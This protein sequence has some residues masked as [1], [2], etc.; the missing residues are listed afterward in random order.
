MRDAIKWLNDAVSSTS[1]VDA[2]SSYQFTTD[3]I[4]A[5]DGRL[6]A[7]YPIAND[8]T[9]RIPGKELERIVKASPGEPKLNLD[10]DFVYVRSGRFN[11]R[12]PAVVADLNGPFEVEPEW[13]EIPDGLLNAMRKVRPFVSADAS[14]MW[15][16]GLIIQNGFCMA[17]NNA[18]LAGAHSAIN[19]AVDVVVPVW[20]LDFILGGRE[21]VNGWAISPEW[22]A[23]RWPSGAWMR[24]VLIDSTMPANVMSMFMRAMSAEPA[25]EI[26]KEFRESYN[27]MAK[28]ADTYIDICSDHIA[29]QYNG[30][31]AV[32]IAACPAL[33]A[34][35]RTRWSSRFLTPVMAVATH[36][37]PTGYPKAAP[38]KGEGIIGLV[39]GRQ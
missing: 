7:C 18:V 39:A 1:I 25:H 3:R 21:D 19:T 9:A 24:S 27:R 14:H 28:L 33:P 15:A 30:S 34:G 35:M 38:W 37:D 12:I 22:I 11:A 16:M 2:Y 29:I 26:T 36:W 20:A 31:E 10:G 8:F 23:F 17:T 6:L 32:E 5:T 4:T 13:S